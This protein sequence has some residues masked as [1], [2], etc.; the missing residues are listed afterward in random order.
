MTNKTDDRN[1][2]GAMG[3]GECGWDQDSFHEFFEPPRYGLPFFA[4]LI[5]WILEDA[6]GNS[7]I[8]S[9]RE[10]LGHVEPFLHTSRS[11]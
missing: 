11:A 8:V 5:A 10:W 1:R 2:R 3:M 4:L 7:H 6:G 9:G